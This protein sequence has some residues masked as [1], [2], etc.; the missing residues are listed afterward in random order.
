[1]HLGEGEN[2]MRLEEAEWGRVLLFISYQNKVSVFCLYDLCFTLHKHVLYCMFLLHIICKHNVWNV[3]LNPIHN[4]H[5]GK[6]TDPYFLVE[7]V[8]CRCHI[9]SLLTLWIRQAYAC[10]AGM[11]EMKNAHKILYEIPE[12]NRLFQRFGYRL[13][14]EVK[15]YCWEMEHDSVVT[16]YCWNKQFCIKPQWIMSSKMIA[17]GWYHLDINGPRINPVNACD[18]TWLLFTSLTNGPSS[19]QWIRF[20]LA[21][22][23]W[24]HIWIPVC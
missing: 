20:R 15:S 4:A 12:R 24:G 2:N 16:K 8:I 10:M 17:S 1:M 23:Y 13:E 9:L 11:I 5:Q 14:V 6:A 19:D 21:A 22:F 3:T 18:L 7:F